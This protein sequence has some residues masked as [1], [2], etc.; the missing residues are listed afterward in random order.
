MRVAQALR[1]R[2]PQ[3][4]AASATS[5]GEYLDA[6]LGAQRLIALYFPFVDFLV[7]HRRRAS[8]SAPAACSSRTASLT[9][10]VADRVPAVPRPV[11]LADPAAVA[12]VRLVAAGRASRST[13]IDELLGHAD[14]DARR[15]ATRS[16][17]AALRGDVALRRRA[18]PLPERRCDEALRGVDLHDRAGR[19]GRARR[20]DRRRQVDAREARR[21]LLRPDGGRGARRRRRPCATSTSVAF[22][23]QLGVVPQEAFL[24]SG[25]IR[26]NIAYGRPDATDAE[27]EARGPR[28]RRPRLH[29]RRCPAATSQPVSE[30]GRSLSPASASSSRSPG[31]SS[32]T[33]R[34]CC[35]TRRRRTSTWPARPRCS[36]RWDR[37]RQGRTTILIAH[38]LPTARPADRILVVDDGRIVEDGNHDE[39]LA[40]RRPLRRAVG[41]PSTTPRRRRLT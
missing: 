32:S 16:I 40:R 4:Q 22:R 26:D 20:R 24:F 36:G 31:P 13:R 19:D 17:P 34:S 14:G 3:H 39:L 33:R 27:V 25:T 35:S 29:R 41:R 11:L 1:A 8:C 12:G 23:R 15:R 5:N 28:R 38:R 37:G 21:P 9:A 30:R 6:R 7:R 18:L 2:G 10:G